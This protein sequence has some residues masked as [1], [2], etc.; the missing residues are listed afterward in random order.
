MSFVIDDD[1]DH[2]ISFVFIVRLVFL[3]VLF[4]FSFSRNCCSHCNYN[5]TIYLKSESSQEDILR[6]PVFSNLKS[7]NTKKFQIGRLGD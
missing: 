6:L 5:L 7:L 1:V 3:S 2:D 4:S